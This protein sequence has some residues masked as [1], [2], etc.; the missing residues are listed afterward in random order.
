MK[1]IYFKKYVPV[2]SCVKSEVDPL[3][4]PEVDPVAS[5]VLESRDDVVKQER[6]EI[7]TVR[8]QSY[9]S[10]LPKY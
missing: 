7:I 5:A 8:G 3:L 2:G 9:L 10:R 4:I 6:G 1:L